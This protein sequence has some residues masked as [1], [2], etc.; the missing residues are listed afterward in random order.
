MQKLNKSRF[1]QPNDP[2]L[3]Q[4]AVSVRPD[5]FGSETLNLVMEHMYSVAYGE[6]KERK[7]PLLVGLAAPQIGIPIRIILVDWLA[8]GKGATGDLRAYFNPT[9]VSHSAQTEEWYEG[10]FS[11]ANVCGIVSRPKG[12]RATWYNQMGTFMQGEFSGYTAR[13]F[14]HE[15]D[16]LNGIEFVTHITDPDKLHLVEPDDFVR[17]RNDGAWRNWPNKCPFSRWN[18]IK[19]A[20]VK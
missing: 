17:Y 12:I 16:H 10:C 19:N 3:R 1:L 4:I 8:D 13:I 14:Q 11:T 20:P 6:Q 2:L 15:V 18:E 5:E 7:R 9:I